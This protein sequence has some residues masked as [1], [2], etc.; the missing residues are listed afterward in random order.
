MKVRKSIIAL[1]LGTLGLGISEYVMMGILPDIAQGVGVSIPKAGYLIS[2]YAIGVVVGAPSMVILA[3]KQP[4]KIILL[5]LAIIFMIGNL[6]TALAPNYSLLAV[7]RFIAGLPHGA[8]FG[9]GSIVATKLVSKG[10]ETAAVAAMVS[11]MTVANLFGSPFG[12]FISHE[13]SWRITYAIVGLIGI[14]TFIFIKKWIPSIDPLPDTGFKGQFSFLK[15]KAPWIIFMAIML[16]NGGVF[17]WWSYINPVMTE[18]SGFTIQ[19]MTGIMMIAGLG[20]LIGNVLSGHFSYKYAPGKIAATTQG[21]MAILLVLILIFSPFKWVSLF[22][23]FLCTM[24]L[25]ALS[26]PEQILLNTH[27]KGGEMLGATLA[28]VAFNLGNAIGA[29]LGGIPIEMG[30]NHKYVTVP[31]IA[32]AIAGFMFLFVF[33]K[34]QNQYTYTHS[35]T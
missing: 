22:L 33:Q 6:L 18:V 25:F 24:C 28:Q 21:I 27:S 3:R 26:A 16:G 4:L 14:P 30:Y 15:H 2:A 7:A 34:K 8:Y 20:M 9:V 10:K 32:L 5:A 19:S 17:C 11:G 29:I 13:F 23:M 31:G 12:T 1:A 35:N